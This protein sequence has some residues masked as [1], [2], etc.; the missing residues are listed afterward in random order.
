ML[1]ILFLCVVCVWFCPLLQAC[2]TTLA[3][4]ATTTDGSVLLSHTADGGGGLDARLVYVPAMD[5]PDGSK[6]SVFYSPENYPRYVGKERN[7]EAYYPEFCEAGAKHCE[8]FEPIGYIPQ[9]NHTYAY[10]E[11]T[12]GIMNEKQVGIGESTC[13]GVFAAKAIDHGGNAL[14]SID[15]LSRIA[16]ERANTA[17]EAISI[18]GS[19]AE[20]YGFY[21]A[22]GS[23]EGGSENLM[24]IDKNEGFV[25]HILPDNTGSS[26]I[27]V[28]QRV[29]DDSVAIVAN[30]FVI[31]EVDLEDTENFMGRKDMFDIAEAE[32]L[33]QKGQPK[34]FTKTFS[35][36]EYA[37]HT[38]SGR[39]IWR[40]FHLLAP[41]AADAA[42]LG[43]YY[44]NL[45]MDAPYP[46]SLALD[47]EDRRLT[48]SD[49]F[50]VNRD[51]YAGTQF[52]TGEGN[53]AGGAYGSPW[54][55]SGGKGETEVK[56]NWER[57]IALARTSSSLVV[58][59][60]SFL[61]D[62]FGGVA[63]FGAH[64]PTS[65]VYTPLLHVLKQAPS[66]LGD[67]WQ[68]RF[69]RRSAFWA[70]RVVGN[71]AQLKWSYG[72][73]EDLNAEQCRLE[74]KGSEL[75]SPA[76]IEAL[77][78]DPKALADELI[79]HSD[80]IVDDFFSFLETLLFRYADGYKNYW[81]ESTDTFVSVS[82]GYPAWWLSTPGV[83]YRTGP[84]DV[85]SIELD[86]DVDNSLRYKSICI[87]GAK[88]CL[89]T[90]TSSD[91]GGSAG[92]VISKSCAL[93]CLEC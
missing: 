74:D 84:P 56:G 54:R 27:W 65:T 2:T 7:I 6:R 20:E 4:K 48:P 91:N 85:K 3:G 61:P 76:H 17:R 35:D 83:H 14:L 58:Q 70:H 44:N 36:G 21:G 73:G 52:S 81:N 64:S 15:E 92:D 90:C 63:W 12:Y 53:L 67:A 26:A 43:P 38:Y 72:M 86:S 42:Q 68:G 34:D 93:D 47:A 71:V 13:S 50:N 1:S 40:A 8:P 11:S 31:R 9:V 24:V 25:F 39:R 80:E 29:P 37:Y 79:E 19:L 33:W 10:F 32:G 45:K 18:M 69:S 30:M 66:A 57:T 62:E 87:N 82:Q 51:Y 28:A 46:F 5:H 59:A 23:F 78:N 55:L 75:V 16:L 88:A 41:K 89:E 22:S 77:N 60:R 49:I